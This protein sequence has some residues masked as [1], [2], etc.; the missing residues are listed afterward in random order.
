MKIDDK[1]RLL[2]RG[3]GKRPIH[4]RDVSSGLRV[5]SPEKNQ[6]GRKGPGEGGD[7]SVR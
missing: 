7:F 1:D 6:G 4:A 5:K 3:G 2:I